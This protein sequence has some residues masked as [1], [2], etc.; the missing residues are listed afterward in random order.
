MKG[1]LN[2]LNIGMV[3][4]LKYGRTVHSLTNAMSHFNPSFFFIAPEALQ[5][6]QNYLDELRHKGIKFAKEENLMK[7]SNKLDILYVTRIQKE[8]FP[9][10]VEYEKYKGYYKL[11]ETLLKNVKPDL[12]IMHALPR[13]DEINRSLDNTKHAVYFEQA[14]NG[15]PVRKALLALVLGKAK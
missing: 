9:D 11:D 7:V 15:I 5:M 8:R 13:V 6:P 1:K 14:A 4:D 12:K 2:N 10:Q 3:G